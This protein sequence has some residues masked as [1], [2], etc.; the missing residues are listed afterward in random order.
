MTQV[1]SLR[2]AL[3]DLAER[4]YGRRRRALRWSGVLVVPAAAAMAA[5]LWLGSPSSAPEISATPTAPQQQLGPAPAATGTATPL[6]TH[7]T[8]IVGSRPFDGSGALRGTLTS[9]THRGQCSAG[10]PQPG[11]YVC[12]FGH[13]IAKTCWRVPG[14]PKRFACWYSPFTKQVALVDVKDTPEPPDEPADKSSSWAVRLANGRQCVALSGATDMA[15]NLPVRFRCSGTLRLIGEIDRS[16]AQWRVRTA[17]YDR[18]RGYRRGPWSDIA[19]S[20]YART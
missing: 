14:E 4:R 9:S 3:G 15:G 17:N 18:D 12:S 10:A 5:A 16:S 11:M 20:F 2:D 6:A 7:T 13:F 1:P 8:R 19:V